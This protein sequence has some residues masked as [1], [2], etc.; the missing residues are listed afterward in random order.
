ML[1]WTPTIREGFADQ[2]IAANRRFPSDYGFRMRTITPPSSE[3]EPLDVLLLRENI[4]EYEQT[5]DN[6]VQRAKEQEKIVREWDIE[7][8]RISDRQYRMTYDDVVRE[9]KHKVREYCIQK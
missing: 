5:V 4:R 1:Q 6:I 8:K 7:L 9:F 3:Y 2:G